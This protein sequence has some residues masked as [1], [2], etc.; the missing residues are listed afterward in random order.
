M[1]QGGNV[2]IACVLCF[3][4]FNL[5]IMTAK[6]AWESVCRYDETV[7]PVKE[8]KRR[9]CVNFTY[10]TDLNTFKLNT[11]K[12]DPSTQTILKFAK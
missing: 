9:P 2:N 7:K 1:M 4:I 3:V 12:L 6:D 5:Y 10:I 8:L 11:F